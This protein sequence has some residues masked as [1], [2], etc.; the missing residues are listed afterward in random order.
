M[1]LEDHPLLLPG[2][3]HPHILPVS[4]SVSETLRSTYGPVALGGVGMVAGRN[5]VE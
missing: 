3:A 1:G 2:S 5:V 4:R